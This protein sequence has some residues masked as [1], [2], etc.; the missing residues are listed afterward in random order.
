V[1]VDTIPPPRLECAIHL[2]AAYRRRPAYK[3]NRFSCY[4]DSSGWVLPLGMFPML[5]RLCSAGS[6][7]CEKIM[8]IRELLRL[9]R[10]DPGFDLS[11]DS[12]RRHRGGLN[13]D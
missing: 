13:I 2:N 6:D 8:L 3:A 1:E 9:A 10:L 12:A 4:F 7:D 11:H 5:D